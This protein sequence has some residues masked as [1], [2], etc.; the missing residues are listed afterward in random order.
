MEL[1]ILTGYI[2]WEDY[3]LDIEVTEKLIRIA[4]IKVMEEIKIYPEYIKKRK[5]LSEE[6]VVI[7]QISPN[8]RIDNKKSD[9]I[10]MQ[11][12]NKVNKRNNGKSYERA[13]YKVMNDAG[14]KPIATTPP[15]R[16]IDVIGEYKGITIYAQ[17][18]DWQSKVTAREIQ[19]LEGVMLNKK[20]SIGVMVSK[21]GYTRDAESYA[22][23]STVKIVLTNMETVVNLIQ[24]AIE[25]M[26][27]Q[28]Q[29]HIEIF[30]RTAEITQTIESDVRTTVI[31]NADKVIIYN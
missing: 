1:D 12:D 27:L 18:K 17:A 29:S 28:K 15:D 14:Y 31:K 10:I 11:E 23:A 2:N 16:G 26:Q 7:Q 4:T 13:L 22:K 5:T 21:S 20:Q 30:G 3:K 24:Q 9:E 6:E 19:Q 25:Q 8:K